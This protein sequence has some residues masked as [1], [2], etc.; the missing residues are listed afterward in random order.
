[1]ANRDQI[2][3]NQNRRP[4]PVDREGRP[5]MYRTLASAFSVDVEFWGHIWWVFEGILKGNKRIFKVAA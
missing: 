3:I 5:Y 2:E 4:V 1:M